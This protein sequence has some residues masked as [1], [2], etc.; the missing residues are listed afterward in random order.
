M[1][2]LHNIERK[3]DYNNMLQ[4]KVTVLHVNKE[5]TLFTLM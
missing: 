4:E 5:N 3:Y 2:F 1:Y